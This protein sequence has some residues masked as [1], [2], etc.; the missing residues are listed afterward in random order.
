VR[1]ENGQELM[2]ATVKNKFETKK[3]DINEA[4]ALFRHLL[5]KMTQNISKTIGWELTAEAEKGWQMNV[6]KK[7]DYVALKKVGERLFLDVAAVMQNQNLDASVDSMSKR[8]WQIMVD[9]TSQF[10]IF[11]FFISEHAMIYATC[12]QIFKFK[13]ENKIV[14]YIRCNDTGKN[15]GLKSRLQSAN[16]EMPI[17]FKFTGCNTP[18][19][20]YL[21][22]VGLDTIASRRRDI[23]SASAIPKELCQKFLEGSF[24]NFNLI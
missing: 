16:W 11:D 19:R 13:E 7:T 8:Y 4:H 5:T 23:M 17:K 10:K 15:Q 20:N 22:N 14:K 18:Q 1:I 12:E 24:S 9:E 3:V 6:E 21:D 2:T